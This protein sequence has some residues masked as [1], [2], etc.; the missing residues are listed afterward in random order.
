MSVTL[1]T[2]QPPMGALKAEASVN[3]ALMSATFDVSHA[4][5]SSLNVMSVSTQSS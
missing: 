5:I 1:D 4:L 2:S 3:V